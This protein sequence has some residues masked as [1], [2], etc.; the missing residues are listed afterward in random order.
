M[1][2]R[3]HPNGPWLQSSHSPNHLELVHLL[4]TLVHPLQCYLS[5]R[6]CNLAQCFPFYLCIF[7]IS[8]NSCHRSWGGGLEIKNETLIAGI[9]LDRN[10]AQGSKRCQC[11][12]HK[13][14]DNTLSLG[15]IPCGHHPPL[16]TNLSTFRLFLEH[17]RQVEPQFWQ[18]FL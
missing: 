2:T 14:L 13:F 18:S 5:T 16:A 10:Y 17:I 7:S 6:G 9:I 3:A 11:N 8:R 15:Y 12:L 4:T 1:K